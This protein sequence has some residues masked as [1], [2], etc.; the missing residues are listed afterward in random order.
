MPIYN[1]YYPNANNAINTL[2]SA[3]RLAFDG[4]LL[5]VTVSVP[6]QVASYLQSRNLSVPTPVSGY[7]LIDTG[8]S[9]CSVDDS[10]IRSLNVPP[11]GRTSINTP[12][13]PADCLTYPASL[14]FPGTTLP[15]INFTDFIG[16]RLQASGIIA[17][18]GRN[19]L[20]S[21]VLVYNGP[22]GSISL[23]Y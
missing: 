12:G 17:L 13:G 4:P 2:E 10:A 21:F 16:A 8:A 18:I 9:M 22:G 1:Q 15:N 14:S 7:A 3:R 20:Q 19:V 6:A 11:F 5:P 23:A